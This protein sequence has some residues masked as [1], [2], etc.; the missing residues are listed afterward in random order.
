M[1]LGRTF[2]V[3]RGDD[4]YLKRIIQVPKYSQI[5]RAYKDYKVFHIDGIYYYCFKGSVIYQ[6]SLYDKDLITMLAHQIKMGMNNYQAIV[7]DEMRR[8]LIKLKSRNIV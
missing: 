1:S 7:V 3:I 8:N 6:S 5:N 4:N 2:I